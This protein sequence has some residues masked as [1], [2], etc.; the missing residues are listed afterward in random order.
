MEDTITTEAEVIET[1]ATTEDLSQL[2]DDELRQRMLEAT[3]RSL[4]IQQ[5]VKRIIDD[6]E[7]SVLGPL[8]EE[9]QDAALA[10][11]DLS[12]E[13][14]RRGWE[15]ERQFDVFREAAKAAN[16]PDEVVEMT[17]EVMGQVLKARR[18]V[19]AIAVKEITK[20]PQIEKL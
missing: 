9:Y 2:N 15:D 4:D 3:K 10:A 1:E 18:Q 16:V 8:G 13:A 12:I 11:N 20:V 6:F 7:E 19:E 5:D 17:L 14:E